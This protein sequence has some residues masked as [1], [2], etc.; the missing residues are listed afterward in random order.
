MIE[1]AENALQFVKSILGGRGADAPKTV[2]EDGVLRQGFEVNRTV[3]AAT[4]L[5]FGPGLYNGLISLSHVA[6]GTLL[7]AINPYTP[8]LTVNELPNPIP[9]DLDWYFLGVQVFIKSTSQTI[10]G[11][12]AELD[13]VV[14]NG[15]SDGVAE[16]DTNILARW[17]TR[18]TLSGLDYMT[19]LASGFAFQ[20]PPFPLRWARDQLLQCRST[21]TGAGATTVHFNSR[22]YLGKRG[23]VPSAF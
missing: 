5:G 2:F 12:T 7:E 6:A 16:F 4:D 18:I 22:W 1:V 3:S 14:M 11:H 9:L 19:N 20:R 23:L 13:G 10:G 8:G 15:W 17:D 21:V